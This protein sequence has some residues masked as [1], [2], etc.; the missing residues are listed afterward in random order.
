MKGAKRLTFPFAPLLY[1]LWNKSLDLKL[2]E[3]R[4]NKTSNQ[5]NRKSVGKPSKRRNRR[6]EAVILL[7]EYD[8]FAR[9]RE[10]Q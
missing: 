9:T 10:Q 4:T 1:V 7:F 5:N 3:S 6:K 2:A 8:Y